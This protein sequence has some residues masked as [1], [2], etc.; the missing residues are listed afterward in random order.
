M[1]KLIALFYLLFYFITAPAPADTHP[2]PDPAKVFVLCFHTFW[3]NEKY[4]YDFSREEFAAILD[5][6]KDAGFK[7][8]TMDDVF[9]TT[10]QGSKNL[11]VTI[12]D[13]NRSVYDAF[14][15]V[16][17]PRN[18]KPVLAI[19]AGSIDK[20][21]QDLTWDQVEELQASGCYIASH[22]WLHLMADEKLYTLS[23]ELFKQE[24]SKSKLVLSE[25]LAQPIV[26][27]IYP[28]GKHIEEDNLEVPRH[29]YLLA[30]GL[31]QKSITLPLGPNMSL[32]NLPRYIF[33]RKNHQDL[34]DMIIKEAGK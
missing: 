26:V 30:F 14:Q 22:G 10:L 19:I 20:I 24:L 17:F 12:D 25:H 18:I 7:F 16:L 11:L 4:F 6:F 29:G 9:A 21:K 3:G 28:Y 13:G 5:Q 8:V 31:G 1:R 27:Y 23:P 15:V 32:Y 34:I 33:D 2:A